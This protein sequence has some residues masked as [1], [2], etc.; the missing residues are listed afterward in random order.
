M[1]PECGPQSVE[2]KYQAENVT[3]GKLANKKKLQSYCGLEQTESAPLFFLPSRLD[4]HQKGCHLLNDI[5]YETVERFWKDNLQIIVIARGVYKRHFEDI[6]RM[7]S[8]SRRVAVVKFD[9]E[10]KFKNLSFKALSK[11]AYAAS[12][13]L[14]IP[15]LYEPCGLTPMTGLIYGSLPVAHETGGLHD[16]I[17]PL[18]IEFNEGNGFLFQVHNARGLRGAIEQ[19]M[20]FYRLPIEK[21]ANQIS[22]IMKESQE[23]FSIDRIA[24]RYM[25]LY[26]KMLKRPMVN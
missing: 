13:F 9:K 6:V 14:L 21:K 12:D 26:E 15:S 18:R 19:A 10:L 24:S 11:L 8:L 7:H 4:A 1:N 3:L 5:L 23:V 20:S 16:T 2:H 25:S 22:R 17:K